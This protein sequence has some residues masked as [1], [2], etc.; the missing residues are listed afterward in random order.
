LF[1]TGG[2]IPSLDQDGGAGIFIQNAKTI[3]RHLVF[4]GHG[5]N[6]PGGV[7]SLINSEAELSDSFLFGN[8]AFTA[9]AIN[10][11][12]SQLTITNV[13]FSNNSSPWGGAIRNEKNGKL[14]IT[15]STFS[16]HSAM[17]GGAIY[18]LAT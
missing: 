2:S 4:S 9:G 12:N 13:N 5:S 16:N 3:L 8:R 10:N 17:V 18:N 6:S 14:T 1:I 15:D 7:L 11:N